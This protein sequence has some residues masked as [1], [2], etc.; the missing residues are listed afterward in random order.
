MRF[1]ACHLDN[2][3]QMYKDQLL[4]L[5]FAETQISQAMPRMIRESREPD[6]KRV[7]DGHLEQT[8]THLASLTGILDPGAALIRAEN[9]VMAA[10]IHEGEAALAS[11]TEEPVRDAI[12][13]AAAQK[14]EHYQIAAYGTLRNFAEIL[15]NLEQA[16]LLDQALDDEKLTDSLLAEIADSA[17]TQ[18]DK[19]GQR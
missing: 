19:A 4:Q 15:G 9:Q 14:L 1:V 12:I 8:R 10:L 18:A 13:I 2:L 6:L 7:L 11:A 3:R 16:E 17:N 5:Y